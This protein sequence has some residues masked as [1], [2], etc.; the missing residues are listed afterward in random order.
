MGIIKQQMFDNERNQ[1]YVDFFKELLN[2]DELSGAVKGIAKQIVDKGIKSMS[3]RQETVI[4]NFIQN[5]QNNNVC[6]R[7][8]NDNVGYLTDYIFINDNSL[9]PQCQYDYDKFMDE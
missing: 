3:K 1:D 4:E 8:S 6:I 9:C 5:Y 7:C 2:R